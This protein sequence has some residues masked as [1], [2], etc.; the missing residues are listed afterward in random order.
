MMFAQASRC[1][2]FLSREMCLG[3]WGVIIPFIISAR[4]PYQ[5]PA[6][7]GLLEE[8]IQTAVRLF[9]NGPP[10]PRGQC[11][12]KNG[13]YNIALRVSFFLLVTVTFKQFRR[14]I[15]L[16]YPAF[17]TLVTLFFCSIFRRMPPW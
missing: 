11:S 16:I 15:S 9:P 8:L 17:S 14:Y 1:D 4:G 5:Q 6:K 10:K 7:S 12:F 13:S 2:A 3:I